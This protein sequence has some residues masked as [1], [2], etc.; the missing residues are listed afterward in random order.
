VRLRR[1]PSERRLACCRC[2]LS[3]ERP[4]NRQQ[5]DQKHR[6]EEPRAGGQPH[7][8]GHQEGTSDEGLF[9]LSERQVADMGSP[10][11][12][13]GRG[14]LHCCRRWAMVGPLADKFGERCPRRDV[15]RPF[16]APV[17]GRGRLT[18]PSRL[19][20]LGKR[21][22]PEPRQDVPPEQLRVVDRVRIGLVPL[23]QRPFAGRDS[24]ATS[25]T[26]LG[27]LRGVGGDADIAADVARVRDGSSTVGTGPQRERPRTGRLPPRRRRLCCGLRR[28]PACLD[29]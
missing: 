3:Y 25:A 6:R 27:C 29:D 7:H 26:D 16:P 11:V 9:A 8:S 13:T 5:T 4:H 19:H 23:R 14:A 20:D 28:C 18:T 1:C 15:R 21:H 22:G 10:S 12:Q 17:V 24:G 2:R